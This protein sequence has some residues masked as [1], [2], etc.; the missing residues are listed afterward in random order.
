MVKIAVL[1]IA[2]NTMIS[3]GIVLFSWFV[4]MR[5]NRIGAWGYLIAGWMLFIMAA[6]VASYLQYQIGEMP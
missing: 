6:M 4:L 3:L 1:I 2:I 5:I